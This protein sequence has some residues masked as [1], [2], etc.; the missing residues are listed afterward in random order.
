LSRIIDNFP[1]QNTVYDSNNGVLTYGEIAGH[2]E[3]QEKQEENVNQN[4]FTMK[5]E[6]IEQRFL[7]YDNRLTSRQSHNLSRFLATDKEQIKESDY[8]DI[9]ELLHEIM[10][11]LIT[12]EELER[13]LAR[14]QMEGLIATTEERNKISRLIRNALSHDNAK[15][16]FSGKYNVINECSILHRDG[17][18]K[19]SRP[20][21]VMINGNKAIVVDFKYARERDKHMKQVEEYMQKLRLMGFK[22]VEG[23][24]WYLYSNRIIPVHPTHEEQ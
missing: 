2:E 22:E 6:R 20:D 14:K 12:G 15:E 17:D 7:S 21:R 13:E 3:K 23:Y 24:L 10:S 5:E 16:W 1:L 19:I 11:H 4:P 9:G 18:Q 8:I